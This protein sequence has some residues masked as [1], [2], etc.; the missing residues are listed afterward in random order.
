MG[1]MSENPRGDFFDSHCSNYSEW[2]NVYEKLRNHYYCGEVSCWE[3]KA[4]RRPQKTGSVEAE[5][6]SC[7][8]LLHSSNYRQ[9]EKHG[10]PWSPYMQQA[11]MCLDLR[12]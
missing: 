5:V 10:H 3:M 7:S 2:P 8:K 4:E 6:T 11:S 9:P 1:K 12:A